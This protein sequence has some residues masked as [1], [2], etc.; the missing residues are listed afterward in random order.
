AHRNAAGGRTCSNTSHWSGNFLNWATMQ[1]IDAFRL[2]MTGGYR[3]KD[4]ANGNTWLEKAESDRYNNNYNPFRTVPLDGTDAALVQGA[5]PGSFNSVRTRIAGVHNQLWFIGSRTGAIGA[6]DLVSR[7]GNE[8]QTG[9]SITA[10]PYNPGTH[11]NMSTSQVYT[12]SVRVQVCDDG[13]IDDRAFCK[14]YGA[15]RKPEGLIQANSKKTRYSVF[16]YQASSSASD[17]AVMRARQKLVAPLSA[18]DR[19]YP[20]R[21]ALSTAYAGS[22]DGG[23]TPPS[24]VLPMDRPEWNPVTGQIYDNPDAPD[25]SATPATVTH[26]GV[27][28]YINRFGSM[29][30]GAKIPLKGNYCFPTGCGG[31]GSDNVSDLYY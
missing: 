16:S 19:P 28:N 11:T 18:G 25:A 13:G 30:T 3:V 20:D 24:A 21:P 8:N 17:G 15:H 1:S 2:A 6:N 27:I 5:M 7:P 14:T 9:G 31:S 26:S 29:N 10:I 23:H 22:N 12:V 4:D